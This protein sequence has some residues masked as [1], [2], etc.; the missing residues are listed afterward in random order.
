MISLMTVYVPKEYQAKLDNHPP[1]ESR[2]VNQNLMGWEFKKKQSPYTGEMHTWFSLKSPKDEVPTIV[3]LHGFNT[4]GTVFFNLMSL[5][6][7]YNLVAYN[8]PDTSVFYK[9]KLENFNNVID[10]F[11]KT[12]NIDY[13]ILA[14][15]SVGGS[16]ALKYAGSRPAKKVTHLILL[17]TNV[18]GTTEENIKQIKGMTEKLMKYPDYK[19][20]YLLLRGR[21]ILDMLDKTR[22]GENIPK[23]TIDIK[24]VAWYRQVLRSLYLYNAQEDA[25]NVTCPVIAF[26]GSEDNMLNVEGAEKITEFIK[27]ARFVIVRKAGHDMVYSDYKEIVNSISEFLKNS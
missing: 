26:H 25:E 18:F 5:A 3:F 19:L 11:L 9:G 27:G 10:D 15:N 7:D 2:I 20:Y 4:N 22:F 17:S 21:K 16:I 23:E 24:H 14:G 8:F 1:I 6:H 12:I 13:L